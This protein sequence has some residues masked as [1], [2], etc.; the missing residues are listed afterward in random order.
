MGAT[1]Q[2]LFGRCHGI[3]WSQGMRGLRNYSH[4]RRVGFPEINYPLAWLRAVS[5]TRTPGR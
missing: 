2:R 1:Q 3:G 5:P 4:E